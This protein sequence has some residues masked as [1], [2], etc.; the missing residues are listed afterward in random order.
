MNSF[1][2]ALVLNGNGKCIKVWKVAGSL[3]STVS[4]SSPVVVDLALRLYYFQ[5]DLS[6][7]HTLTYQV[8]I[9]LYASLQPNRCKH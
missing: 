6:V 7:T 9:S 5:E 1:S 3:Q 8:N 2:D 4:A